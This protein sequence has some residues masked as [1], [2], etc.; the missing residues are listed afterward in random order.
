MWPP[1]EF[2]KPEPWVGQNTSPSHITTGLG[3]TGPLGDVVLSPSVREDNGHSGHP[4]GERPGP[5]Y[6]GKTSLKHM[7]QGQ[8]GHR[9]LAHVFHVGHGFFHVFGRAEVSQGKLCADQRG[10]LEQPYSSSFGRNRQGIYNSSD[11]LFHNLKIIFS[12]ALGPID[13]KNQVNW[14]FSASYGNKRKVVMVKWLKKNY[15]TRR[16]GNY[17][18]TGG[19]TIL[20][21]YFIL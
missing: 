6:L 12:K 8:P 19:I 7:R 1:S 9:A 20:E 3:F 15:C 21:S 13:H 4:C 14:A 17:T 16:E 18:S 11:K 2:K 5:F 10:I